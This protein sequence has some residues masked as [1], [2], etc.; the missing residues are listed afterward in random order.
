[1]R[2]FSN[3]PRIL[4]AVTA[5]VTAAIIGFSIFPDTLPMLFKNEPAQP[6]PVAQTEI[7]SLKKGTI[8]TVSKN[9]DYL[10]LETDK[11]G[12]RKYFDNFGIWGKRFNEKVQE[13]T[14]PVNSALIFL[15]G[16]ENQAAQYKDAAGKHQFSYSLSF[17]KDVL[18]VTVYLPPDVLS[19][20]VA[21]ETFSAG[22]I[23]ALSKVSKTPLESLPNPGPKLFQITKKGQIPPLQNSSPSAN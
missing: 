10:L 4:L 22:V 12:L 21:S 14:L 16:D 15:S 6:I 5:A 11:E 2:S 9:D 8:L 3:N 18:I 23:Y 7:S 20:S 17:N 1:M 13:D 19:S